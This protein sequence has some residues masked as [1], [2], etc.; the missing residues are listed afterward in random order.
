MA[1]A[2]ESMFYSGETPWHGLG[3]KVDE[4][5]T[6]DLDAC[7]R[8]S[9][10]DW[11]VEKAPLQ[12]FDGVS[13]P[14]AYATRRSKDGRIFGV[15]GNQYT[16][17]QNLDAFRWFEPFLETRQVSLETA[18]SLHNG[19][20]VWVL[21]RIAENLKVTYGDEIAKYLLL[22]HSHNGRLKI[23]ASGTPIRVV[24][25]NT[26]RLSQQDKKT[27]FYLNT[28]H[29]K[30][31]ATRMENAREEIAR[32]NHLFLLEQEK[33]VFLA[34]KSC[35]LKQAE[36]YFRTYL[37]KPCDEYLAT[38]TRHRVERLHELMETGMGNTLPGV[39]GTYWA[40]FN[41]ITQSQTWEDGRNQE[42][43]LHTLWFDQP[44]VNALDLAVQLA[45]A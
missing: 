13:V 29:T 33:Y 26:L 9:G 18:G 44:K 39:K 45:S 25:Q 36:I 41:A 8:A 12:T 10:L 34:S 20:I 4:S 19:E 7:I 2:V 27:Q 42:N 23:Q 22:A 31:M 3:V 21:A 24:C 37:E 1:H 32:A 38:R 35:N 16:I 28:R 30:N 40:A 5:A 11:E 15:V 43:R 17:L 6:Y 14:D